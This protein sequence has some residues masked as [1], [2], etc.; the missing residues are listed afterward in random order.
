MSGVVIT[1]G[2][3]GIGRATAEVLVAEGR[4]VA[5]WDLD[6]AVVATAAGVL[7]AAAPGTVAFGQTVDVT[8]AGQVA[9]AADAAVAAL[10][11][12]DGFVH[13]AGAVSPDPLGSLTPTDW[14]RILEV[15]LTAYA[16]VAQALLEPLRAAAG[17]VAAGRASTGPAVVG[18]SSIEGLVGNAAIPSY[19]ASKA[20]L[21][22]V[23]RSLAHQLGPEGIRVNAVCPG[24]VE[25]PMLQIALD[26]PG[27]REEME[28]EAPLGRLARPDEIGQVVAFLL[29]ERAS[30]VT[31]T[32]L[33]V[34]GGAT[35]VL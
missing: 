29:S 14:N 25:T 24:F 23:T 22:G 34:D 16:F 28:A 11:G 8:D 5:L 31:G 7:E 13:A 18:I 15:N 30:F 12:I 35:A 9:A 10:G 6:P 21:L 26:V 17:E 20:G 3:S 33:V 19:C 27:M 4:S 32:H 2:A 1:G